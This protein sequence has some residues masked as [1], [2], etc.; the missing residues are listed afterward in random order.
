MSMYFSKEW[1][2]EFRTPPQFMVAPSK[3]LVKSLM[4]FGVNQVSLFKV[5]GKMKRS[6]MITF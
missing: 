5:K 3:L 6:Q 4:T 1:I 2:I